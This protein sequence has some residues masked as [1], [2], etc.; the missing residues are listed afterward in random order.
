MAS[1]T[2]AYDAVA[3]IGVGLL[4]AVL[5]AVHENQEPG[6]PAMPHAVS[7]W[8]DDTYR[9]GSDPLPEA[10]RTGFRARVEVQV[11]TP[12]VSLP[13]DGLV[14]PPLILAAAGGAASRSEPERRGPGPETAWLGRDIGVA[15][16]WRG[17]Q[18]ATRVRVR[19]W[20]RDGEGPPLPE[21]IDGNLTVSTGIR[22][23]DVTGVGTFLTM[24]RSSGPTVAFEPAPGTQITDEQ[25][26]LVA[27]IV[28]NVIRAN[29]APETFR[30]TVPPEVRHFDFV[31]RPEARRPCVQL[32]LN[33]T[34]RAVGPGDR[35]SAAPGILPDGADFAIAVS[36][37]FLIAQFASR[38]FQGLP[39]SYSY[40]TWGV[41]ATVRPDW[42]GA[43]FELEPGRV[44]FKLR[45]DGDISWFGVDDHFTFAIQQAFGLVLVGGRIDVV[46][47][48]DP[49]VDLTDVA[50]GGGYLEGKA[51]DTIRAERDAALAQAGPQ[52]RRALDLGRHLEQILGGFHPRPAGVAITGVQLGPDGV[53]A[54]GTVALAAS[55]PVVVAHDDRGGYRDALESWIPG[56]TV[57][58][59][60]WERSRFP[61]GTPEVHVEEHRFVTE[62]MTIAIMG[63]VCL[64]VEGTRVG[65]GGSILP[66]SLRTCLPFIPVIGPVNDLPTDVPRP[67][68]PFRETLADGTARTIGHYDP[69][70]PGG[71]GGDTVLLLLFGSEEGEDPAELLREARKRAKKGD[72]AIVAVTIAPG[73]RAGAAREP[74]ADIVVAEDPQGPWAEAFGVSTTPAAVL[75]G[76]GGGGVWRG[77][78]AKEVTAARLARA[79]DEHAVPDGRMAMRPIRLPVRVGQRVPDAS[80]RLAGG[81]ELSLR[82]LRGRP[83]AITFWSSRS[84]P[85]LEQLDVLRDVA[86]RSGGGGPLVVAVGDGESQERATEVAKERRLPYLV[87]PDPDRLVSSAFG[88]WCWPATVWIRPDLRVEAIDVG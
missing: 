87:L 50:V 28:R 53:L 18:V 3:E 77:T 57:D 82:R 58:R 37:D 5:G 81:G 86:D 69:W 55:G 14:V 83:I 49:V 40:S 80:L 75:V 70:G 65:P 25:R 43:T 23:S 63:S 16:P 79:I 9:G 27:S 54:S 85:S 51:R 1:M 32:L 13:V 34:D 88:V 66:V 56:G 39:A 24:D 42:A 4:N 76:P 71:A 15:W 7:G 33:L 72:A 59:F 45:G 78:G 44:V 67:V 46:A 62:G 73:D 20:V 29:L 6:Y 36:R 68:L 84:A 22:R 38:L 21:F 41:G 48:G 19:A 30:V 64:M 26:Q 31:L 60:T 2:G 52:I 47:D 35:G 12:I 8:I 61:R 10:E 11:S 74:A 17:P